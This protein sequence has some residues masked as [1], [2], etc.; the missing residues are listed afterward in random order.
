VLVGDEQRARRLYELLLPHADDNAVSYTQ[1]P[2][3]PVALRLGKLAATLAHWQEADRH[4]AAA[5][6]R[7]ELLGARAIAARV[8]LVHAR[9]LAARGEPADAGRLDAMLDEAKELCNELGMAG[10]LERFVRRAPPSEAR[11]AD[12]VFRHEGEFW[13]VAWGGQTFRLRDVK[14]LR[15][16]AAL[17]AAPG[18]QV[19][20]LELVSAVGGAQADSRARLA[21][22]DL[23]ASR[24]SDGGPLLDEQAKQEYRLRLE[25]LAEDLEEARGWGDTERAARAEEEIDALTQALAEAVGLGGRDRTF[26]SPAER[27]R[28]NVTKSI[29]T[30]VKLVGN[31]S[32]ELAA[33]LDASIQTGRFCSYA[34]PGAAPPRWS[35]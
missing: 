15:Y 13:T 6:A 8:L 33:H 7:C 5:L 22:D 19:H 16:I 17:L 35:L 28:V 2:F 4:F 30:A 9:A 1:Q 11:I 27:A 23:I 32:P 18:R 14:G 10:L 24:P 26:A 31:H 21:E 25:Q 34:T 20:V 29:R 12:A 3:G